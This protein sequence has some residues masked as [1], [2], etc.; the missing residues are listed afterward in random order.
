VAGRVSDPA[1]ELPLEYFTDE[2]L[3]ALVEEWRQNL[4]LDNDD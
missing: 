3:A 2:E 4:G 1:M